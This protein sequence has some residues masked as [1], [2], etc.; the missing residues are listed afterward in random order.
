[1]LKRLDREDVGE[2]LFSEP[3]SARLPRSSSMSMPGRVIGPV[4]DGH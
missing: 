4:I 2:G 1:M 3:D